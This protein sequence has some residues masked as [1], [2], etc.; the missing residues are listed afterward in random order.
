MVRRQDP[1]GHQPGDKVRLRA[2]EYQ[3]HRGVIL[4]EE[5]DRVQ[6]ELEAG[7]TVNVL[8]D[9]LTNYSLAARRAWKTMPKKAGR[10][11][12][13]ARQKRPVSFRLDMDVWKDLSR[14]AELGLIISREQAV[15]EWLRQALD[16]LLG[17]HSEPSSA[18]ER[19]VE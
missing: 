7:E 15:N 8:P 5:E 3:G 4:G 18:S 6:V 17:L 16:Q 12:A 1:S 13:H 2:G 19:Q 11:K 10:P 14:A 9:E